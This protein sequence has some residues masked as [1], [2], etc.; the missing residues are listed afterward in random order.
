MEINI[1]NLHSEEPQKKYGCTKK[2]L[3]KAKENPAELYKYF[4]NFVEL[5]DSKN[6]ILKW[7]AIDLIGYMAPVDKE[8]K[9]EKIK[10]KIYSMLN[11][12]RMITAHHA[13]FALTIIA[14]EKKHLLDEIFEQILKVLEYN[15]DKPDCNNI[16]I[17]K[18][19]LAFEDLY[20]LLS[21]KQKTIVKQIASEQTDNERKTTQKKAKK[22]LKRIKKFEKK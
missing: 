2:L 16:V 1:K 13:I 20:E 12:G 21:E 10:K 14:K 15:Y 3:K 9:T 18:L 8:K 19:I 17:G 22:L 4:D 6:Q 7:T 11:T 5:F